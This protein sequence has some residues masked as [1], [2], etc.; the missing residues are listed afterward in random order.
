MP[1]RILVVEDNEKNA[2]LL[3]DVLSYH[4]YEVIEAGNGEKG[5]N[6]AREHRPD[7]ILMDM[8]MPVMDGFT[9]M[10]ILKGD[11]DTR[12][13]KIIVVTSSAMAGDRERILSAGADYYI[14]KPIDIRELPETVKRF[15]V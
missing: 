4:G 2:K 9:A 15:L 6:M 13:I 7:L 5:V 12:G 3:R 1:K 10:S 11:P 8:Q 14:S